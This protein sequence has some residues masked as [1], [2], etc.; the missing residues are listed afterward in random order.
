M[1]SKIVY[2]DLDDVCADFYKA[3]KDSNGKVLE[4]R[5]FNKN[6][7]LNLE[8][9]PGAKAGIFQLIKMGFDVYILSQ[10]FTQL[11]ESY[12]EKA[13]W[14]QLHLPQLV[15]KIILTQNKGLHLGDYLIDD[16]AKK[17]QEKFEHN[18]GK[19]IH[20]PYGGYNLDNMHNPEI[21]WESIVE[22]M[23]AELLHLE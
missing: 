6:F 22:S 7:F 18:G 16:N 1:N 5:M 8:P 21:L 12:S 14:V 19:F 17:W 23:K 10:P 3:A 20:F 9:V 2:I 4:E 13:Q 15:N 11:P